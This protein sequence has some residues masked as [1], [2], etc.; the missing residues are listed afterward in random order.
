MILILIMK[1]N[2]FFFLDC[3]TKPI[4]NITSICYIMIR[5]KLF[6]FRFICGSFRFIFILFSKKNYFQHIFQFFFTQMYI[7]LL[8][9]KKIR[10][11]LLVARRKLIRM[12]YFILL[13][14]LLLYILFLIINVVYTI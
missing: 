2:P 8:R 12:H 4:L 10:M 6:F 9:L 3:K 5:R 1:Y 7:F 13:V 11:G 14:L